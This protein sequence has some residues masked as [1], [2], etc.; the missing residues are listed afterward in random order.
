M[1]HKDYGIRQILK[2]LESG[3][4]IY[5]AVKTRLYEQSTACVW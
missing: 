3:E 2:A 1:P 4:I 5:G